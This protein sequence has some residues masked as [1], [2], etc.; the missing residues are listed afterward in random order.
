MS[1]KK[2]KSILN[3]VDFFDNREEAH[4]SAILSNIS[5]KKIYNDFLNNDLSKGKL[6]NKNF[7]YSISLKRKHYEDIKNYYDYCCAN[8]I[9]DEIDFINK[10]IEY[11][12]LFVYLIDYYS[13]K[14]TSHAS[15]HQSE[16]PLS[17]KF[18]YKFLGRYYHSVL[19]FL[20]K[21]GVVDYTEK[22]I[23]S[24]L[25]V[26]KKG[27]C[28]HYWLCD[29][30]DEEYVT[31]SLS[32]RHIISK[33]FGKS[34]RLRGIE[35]IDEGIELDKSILE[36]NVSS[37]EYENYFRTMG[38]KVKI[39]RDE[40]GNRL[41]HPYLSLK[42]EV[43]RFISIDGETD[44]SMLDIRN[45]HPY[46][47]SM[48]FHEDFRKNVDHLLSKEEIK[49][50]KNLSNNPI[51]E[52][53]IEAFQRITSAGN[54]YKY[55]ENE[56][57]AH[58]S[59]KELNMY[60]FYGSFNKKNAIYRLFKNNFSFIN[61]FKF[62]IIQKYGHKRLSSLLQRVESFIVIDHLMKKIGDSGIKT[63]T[64]HDAFML[65]ECDMEKAICLIK[66]QLNVMGVKYLP[67]FNGYKNELANSFED[68][69]TQDFF[70]FINKCMTYERLNRLIKNAGI[71]NR[72]FKEDMT[73]ESREY[74][75]NRLY[76]TT[77]DMSV[78]DEYKRLLQK[79]DTN[80]YSEF[81]DYSLYNEY[82]NSNMRKKVYFAKNSFE[83]MRINPIEFFNYKN[84]ENFKTRLKENFYL[85]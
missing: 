48:L 28:R 68:I 71:K 49:F 83:Y 73:V 58:E 46:F 52:K 18:I 84:G 4:K 36:A 15:N 3:S 32:N 45:S 7:Y 44:N 19:Y 11:I 55:L 67:S 27:L 60:Y 39:T 43:R 22:Y 47:F 85:Y 74:I 62:F 14:Y 6:Y 41:Y 38:G 72:I 25:D 12:Y 35:L 70:L 40:F 81:D 75:S 17:V 80:D 2:I 42:K 37:D 26:H 34:D 64:F 57:G 65:R 21:N 59:M 76:N 16:T 1:N 8:N 79:I 50:I 63:I 56:L 29:N 31:I 53:Q 13:T 5:S 61:K 20:Q 23:P 30:N 54:Y 78:I 24:Y 10:K 69:K 82:K 66:E 33:M 9:V 77:S 51:Y